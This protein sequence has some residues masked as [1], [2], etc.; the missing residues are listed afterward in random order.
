VV[1]FFVFWLAYGI[2]RSIILESN[3]AFTFDDLRHFIVPYFQ[4]YGEMFV[5][6]MERT[7]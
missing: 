1:I 2:A 4:M 3:E 5:S 7:G 6:P